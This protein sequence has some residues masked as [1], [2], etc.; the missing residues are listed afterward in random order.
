MIM[1]ELTTERLILRPMCAEYLE[2]THE[3]ASDTETCR[4]MVY[5]PSD[6]IEDTLYY[7]IDAEA[8]FAKEKPSYYEMAVFCGDTHIGAVSLYLD[9]KMEKGELG[10]T[11]NKKYHGHGYATE[12]ARALV[13]YASEELG[14]RHFIAHCDAEN[15]PSSKVMEKLGMKYVSEYG[16]RKNKLSDEERMERLYELVL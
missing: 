11:I 2:T 10:W 8:E 15:I 14:I 3:Y 16:G 9:D 6:S 5:L 1:K 4:F 7:L 12:A 13:K